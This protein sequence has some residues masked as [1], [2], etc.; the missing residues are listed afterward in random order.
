MPATMQTM[1]AT[2][3]TTMKATMHA[4]M[5]STIQTL[6]TMQGNNGNQQQWQILQ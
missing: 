1:P 6:A 4:T 5:T 2:M 3:S